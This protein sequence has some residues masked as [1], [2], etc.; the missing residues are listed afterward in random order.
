[1]ASKRS[2]SS[3]PVSP[4][5]VAKRSA[6][7]AHELYAE[8]ASN[9]LDKTVIL[10][11]LSDSSA[12]SVRSLLSTIMTSSNSDGRSMSLKKPDADAMFD[13]KIAGKFLQLDN[14][15]AEKRKK[16]GTAT[17]GIDHSSNSLI[18]DQIPI[19]RAHVKLPDGARFQ[20][21]EEL[22]GLWLQYMEVL[23]APIKSNMLALQTTL[24]KADLH[25]CLLSVSQ[26]KCPT[27]VGQ[28]GIILQET[29]H[30]FRIITREH[31][32]KAI[33]KA[34]SVF[35]FL[36]NGMTVQLFGNHLKMRAGERSVKKFKSKASIEL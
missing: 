19:L 8:L 33:P 14:I 26:S 12:A 13:S 7:M 30:M 24:S 28:E 10:P 4:G 15:V 21:Y 27:L 11:E 25:G 17:T 36:L 31:S 32:L 16:T 23:T 34:N 3:N 18:H 2:A 29:A 1:M 5:P 9:A 6:T 20:D 35:S 22:H